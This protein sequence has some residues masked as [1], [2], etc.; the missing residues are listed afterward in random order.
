LKVITIGT[1][2]GGT[3]KTSTL[4]NLAGL[5]AERFNVLLIDVDPQTNLSLNCGVDITVKNLKTSK[6]IFEGREPLNNLIFKSPVRE[7]PNMDIIPSSIGM[8]AT[9]L[10]IVSLAGRENILRNFFLDNEEALNA[11]DYILIDTNPSM[12][13][14]NQNAF[15]AADSIILISDISLNGIQGAE[16][17]ITLWGGIRERLRKA[18][19]IKALVINNYDKRIKL[20]AELMDYCKENDAISPII[21]NTVIYNSVQIKNSELEHKPISLLYKNS[22]IHEAYKNI[23]Q[24]LTERGVL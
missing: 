23:A 19:N 12:G 14:I 17:F 16:L 5:L 6:N 13:V 9:E 8:T 22:V 4:F 3:G 21:L 24:E 7:L 1:L 10:Q 15:L 18:D 11:Y 2:K 20:S